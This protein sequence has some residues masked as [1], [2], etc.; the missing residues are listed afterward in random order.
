M[1]S[2]TSRGG[3]FAH[4]L[5]DVSNEGCALLDAIRGLSLRLHH[6]QRGSNRARD[7]PLP[8]RPHTSTRNPRRF[9]L[10]LGRVLDG[11]SRCLPSWRW[12][13]RPSSKLL[14]TPRS[15]GAS[16]A[17]PRD[18]SSLVPA[19]WSRTESS[20]ISTEQSTSAGCLGSTSCSSS[21]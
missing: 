12:W 8:D 2:G 1:G 3:K 14:G 7:P 9:S 11:W 6:A 15:A 18:G 10:T 13:S 19:C 4:L 17:H 20:S 16:L 21:W 5:V